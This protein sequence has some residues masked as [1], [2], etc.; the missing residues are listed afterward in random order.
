MLV[1]APAPHQQ[2]ALQPRAQRQVVV[3]EEAQIVAVVGVCTF[4]SA[5]I[6]QATYT[7]SLA[8]LLVVVNLMLIRAR[9]YWWTAVALVLLALTR[10]VVIAMV[11][12][13]LAHG[14]ADDVVP[15]ARAGAAEAALRRLGVP[16][17]TLW[18]PGLGH[19][20]DDAGLQAGAD[21]LRPLFT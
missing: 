2:P 20:I 16:L 17:Q 15:F 7:E 5:P 6:M 9:R 12:V 19:A 11:P 14:M 3:V 4:I 13:L 1:L 10:N 8:L 21:F 18:R